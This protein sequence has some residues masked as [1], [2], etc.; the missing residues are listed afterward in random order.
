MNQYKDKRIVI[1]DID[2]TIADCKHRLH[3]IYKNPEES[4]YE[5]FYSQVQ[6]DKPIESVIS[7]VK[8]M[9]N[10]ETAII[11]VSSRPEKY[12]KQTV[13]WLNEHFGPLGEALLLRKAGDFR[14]ANIVKEEIYEE[15]LKDLNIIKVFEDRLNIIEMWRR[16]GLDVVECGAL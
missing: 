14:D 6:N 2:G 15:H 7:E 5:R 1:C 8:G 12:R 3:Y 9:I 10:D 11:F 16:K 13:E 4:D